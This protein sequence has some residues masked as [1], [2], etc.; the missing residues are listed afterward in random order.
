MAEHKVTISG[1]FSAPD[2][3]RKTYFADSPVVIDISGLYWGDTVTSPFTIVRVEVVYDSK[4]VGEFKAD[5]G[6]QTS[7]SFDISSALRAIWSDF[8]YGKEVAAAKSAAASAGTTAF[9]PSGDGYQDG[10]RR[11]REY[12]LQVYTEYL[13]NDDGISP[14]ETHDWG[15]TLGIMRGSGS[16]AYVSEYDDPDDDENNAWEIV[17][18]SSITAHPDTCDSYGNEWM[19]SDGVRGAGNILEK[20]GIDPSFVSRWRVCDPDKLD[21]GTYGFYPPYNSGGSYDNIFCQ[22]N[23]VIGERHVMV[24]PICSDG[25]ILTYD[26]YNSY[27][28]ELKEFITLQIPH[29]LT[30]KEC[31]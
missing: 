21:I 5:T 9:A 30:M 29:F 1:M 3:P 22:N 23:V 26:Q 7:I 14:I 27:V 25:E 8:D 4:A 17:P 12:Y 18:G 20:I 28:D 31:V 13:S 24:T 16:D 2:G 11:Y 19:Y 15:L 6:R 10:V